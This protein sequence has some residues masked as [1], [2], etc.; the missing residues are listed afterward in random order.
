MVTDVV[1]LLCTEVVSCVPNTNLT[2]MSSQTPTKESTHTHGW[3][4][5][6]I[7]HTSTYKL[8]QLLFPLTS[9]A[10]V[11]YAMSQETNHIETHDVSDM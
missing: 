9:S 8:M 11:Q 2:D 6:L 4:V 10:T 3:V 5:W 1:H 7:R